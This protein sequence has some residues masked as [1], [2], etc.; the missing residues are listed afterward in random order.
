L[1][2]DLKDQTKTDGNFFLIIEEIIKIKNKLRSRDISRKE[3]DA[4]SIKIEEFQKC[5]LQS[6]KL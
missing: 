6:E 3:G 5:F 1:C 4:N 2:Q